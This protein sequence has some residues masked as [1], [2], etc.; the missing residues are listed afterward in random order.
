MLRYRRN[1]G[2]RAPCE[3]LI[4]L[5]AQP[6]NDEVYPNFNCVFFCVTPL[7]LRCFAWAEILGRWRIRLVSTDWWRELSITGQVHDRLCIGGVAG[8]DKNGLVWDTW[9][10]SCKR[11]VNA[12]RIKLRKVMKMCTHVCF[13]FF[14]LLHIIFHATC[15]VPFVGFSHPWGLSPARVRL[16]DTVSQSG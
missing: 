15:V 9:E 7:L 2:S 6:N 11:H 8:G 10:P 16:K 14:F 3:F 1:K 5:W 13:F 4:K 12:S